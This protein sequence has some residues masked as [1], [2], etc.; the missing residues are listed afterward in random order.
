MSITLTICWPRLLEGEPAGSSAR[1]VAASKDS[2]LVACREGGPVLHHVAI[3]EWG[4]PHLG[5]MMG[6]ITGYHMEYTE[7]VHMMSWFS[8]LNHHLWVQ[9]HRLQNHRFWRRY[10]KIDGGKIAFRPRKYTVYICIQQFD[11]YEYAKK[12]VSN[13]TRPVHMNQYLPYLSV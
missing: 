2:T 10:I 11:R 5:I 8:D 4:N 7:Y 6:K 9:N 13:Y 3:Q 12:L 1:R